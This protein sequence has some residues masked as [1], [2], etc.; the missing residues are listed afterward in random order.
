MHKCAWRWAGLVE[1]DVRVWETCDTLPPNCS[2]VTDKWEVNPREE[3]PTITHQ[4]SGLLYCT[5]VR[6]RNRE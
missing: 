3:L 1:S 4:A 6:R 2:R 5:I